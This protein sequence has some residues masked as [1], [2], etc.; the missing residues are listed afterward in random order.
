MAAVVD[1]VPALLRFH[2]RQHSLDQSQGSEEVHVKQFLG[3]ID[4]DTFH[5]AEQSY[6]SIVNCWAF[7]TCSLNIYRPVPGTT[8]SRA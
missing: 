5:Y 2:A 7:K 4:W 8:Y 6:P 3:H 1:N